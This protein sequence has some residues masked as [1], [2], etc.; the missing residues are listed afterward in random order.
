MINGDNGGLMVQEN[1]R[2][3]EWEKSDGGIHRGR[4]FRN[5]CDRAAELCERPVDSGGRRH[6]KG[7]CKTGVR[8]GGNP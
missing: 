7:K 2:I 1:V 8:E 5:G 6:I 4:T 3:P